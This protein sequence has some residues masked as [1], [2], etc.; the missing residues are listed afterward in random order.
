MLTLEPPV[1]PILQ[2]PSTPFPAKTLA[3][4]T[5]D[6]A[7]V[8]DD[9]A[10]GQKAPRACTWQGASGRIYLHRVYD[11][12]WCPEMANANVV[13]VYRTCLG[14][15][16]VL[17]AGVV[18][19]GAPSLNLAQIRQLGAQLG[20][21]EIHVYDAEDTAEDRLAVAGDLHRGEVED[22]GV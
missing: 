17:H 13:F 5:R 6:V 15:R 20:A 2:S 10:P 21:N 1:R 11:F 16:T 22:A 8:R 7:R 19:N 14:P 18:E 12:I 9:H 4:Q 3:R